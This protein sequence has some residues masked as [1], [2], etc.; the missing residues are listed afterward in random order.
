MA[1]I[2]TSTFK[3]YCMLHII[4]AELQYTEVNLLDRMFWDRVNG[5]AG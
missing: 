4:D 1:L 5:A 2:A 3:L